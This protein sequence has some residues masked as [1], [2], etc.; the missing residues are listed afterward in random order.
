MKN[1]RIHFKIDKYGL[2][3]APDWSLLDPLCLLFNFIN[4]S[5]SGG[6]CLGLLGLN[7][8]KNKKNECLN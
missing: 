2:L 7:K 8:T 5:R 1:I 6:P 4:G 3:T